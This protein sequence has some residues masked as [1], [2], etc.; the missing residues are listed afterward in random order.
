MPVVW[1]AMSCALPFVRQ[2]RS[3][4]VGAALRVPP[5]S[6]LPRWRV[7]G[8][9]GAGGRDGPPAPRRQGQ[10]RPGRP[11]RA[12]AIGGTQPD[13]GVRTAAARRRAARWPAATARA[14]GSGTGA[15]DE[16]DQAGKPRP[17]RRR[18]RRPG[19]A[20]RSASPSPSAGSARRSRI[21]A[22][23]SSSIE[24]GSP[25]C[26]AAVR[27]FQSAGCGSHGRGGAVGAEPERRLVAGPR[28]R[29]PAAVPAGVDPAGADPH[30]VLAQRRTGCP[31]PRQRPSSSP[32]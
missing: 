25:V 22:R 3:P 9:G 18:A 26:A 20:A 28:Q 23:Y 12:S 11:P 31:R 16:V 24:A 32:W 7:V 10:V 15:S 5:R 13:G 29:H 6:P 14:A 27:S 30:R 21:A 17:R 1:L 4:R 2:A 19:R 8:G